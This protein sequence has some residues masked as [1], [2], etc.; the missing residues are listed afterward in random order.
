MYNAESDSIS[1]QNN[2]V[3]MY[4]CLCIYI[5]RCIKY[6]QNHCVLLYDSGNSWGESARGRARLCLCIF[7]YEYVFEFELFLMSTL[8]FLKQK[9]LH[10]L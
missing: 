7:L 4:V 5:C 6:V 1:D 3:T 2:S 10:F 9:H 8:L